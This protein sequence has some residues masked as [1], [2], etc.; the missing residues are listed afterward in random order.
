MSQEKT[1]IKYKLKNQGTNAQELTNLKFSGRL[2]VSESMSHQNQQLACKC[3]ELKS[4][5]KIHS[6]WFFNN[7]I[8]IKLIEHGRI[9]KIFHV[10]DIKNLLEIDNLEKLITNASF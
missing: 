6:T 9:H 1:V 3:R 10:A 4:S 5:R 7:V 2:F 8:N